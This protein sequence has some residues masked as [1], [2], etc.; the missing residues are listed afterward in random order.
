MSTRP[1]MPRCSYMVFGEDVTIV[2]KHWYNLWLEPQ[3]TWVL[4]PMSTSY[5]KIGP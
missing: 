3:Q 1:E 4:L 5:Q 2:K